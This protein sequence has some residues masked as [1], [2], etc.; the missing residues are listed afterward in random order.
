M[1]A[2]MASPFMREQ[3]RIISEKMLK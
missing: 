1:N 2:R 3:H